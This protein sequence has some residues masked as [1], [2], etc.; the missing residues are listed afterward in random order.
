MSFILIAAFRDVSNSG[1]PAL[2]ENRFVSFMQI[3]HNLP[4][5]NVVYFL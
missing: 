3:N 2:F 4:F 1:L 5:L